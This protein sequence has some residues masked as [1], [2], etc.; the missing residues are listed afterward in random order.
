MHQGFVL[1]NQ[2]AV[3]CD[4]CR[5]FHVFVKCFTAHTIFIL[6]SFEENQERRNRIDNRHLIQFHRRE[7]RRKRERE[8]VQKSKRSMENGIHCRNVYTKA[9]AIRRLHY[10]C[11]FIILVSYF[12]LS[13]LHS[14]H[15]S[16]G[17]AH[18]T[19]CSYRATPL[20]LSIS[21]LLATYRRSL[22]SSLFSV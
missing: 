5:T 10:V 1:K 8:S 18:H 12:L 6:S 11:L 21:S 3:E 4:Y 15:S 20:N 2:F 16:C 13:I 22:L 17:M 19:V 7:R 14:H 9:R